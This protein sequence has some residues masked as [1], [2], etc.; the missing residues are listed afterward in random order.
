MLFGQAG[1][2]AKATDAETW[3]AQ[4]TVL[5]TFSPRIPEFYGYSIK[6]T[7]RRLKRPP[8]QVLSNASELANLGARSADLGTTDTITCIT[9]EEEEDV[10]VVVV[11]SCSTLANL[12]A[13]SADLGTELHPHGA[14]SADPAEGNTVETSSDKVIDGGL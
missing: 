1:E 13:R 6:F 2:A 11:V 3:L 10:V 8:R 4:A 9:V 14:L 12:G 5:H 7:T